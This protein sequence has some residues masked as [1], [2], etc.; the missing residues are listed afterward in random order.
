MIASIF[1]FLTSPL[2]KGERLLG[3][4][5]GIKP[6]IIGAMIADIAKHDHERAELFFS[7]LSRA[8]KKDDFLHTAALTFFVYRTFYKNRHPKELSWWLEHFRS[9]GVPTEI[10]LRQAEQILVFLRFAVEDPQDIVA[11]Y[12]GI[13]DQKPS[14]D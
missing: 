2:Y 10:R 8:D 1:G 6:H 9:Q 4:Y 7:Y 11:F 12:L 14:F 3:R 13:N 5:I